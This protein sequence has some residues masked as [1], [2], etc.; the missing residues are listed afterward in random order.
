[1]LTKLCQLVCCT[2]ITSA[3]QIMHSDFLLP[4]VSLHPH[5]NV[6]DFFF[7]FTQKKLKH[8]FWQAIKPPT[9]AT[10][11]MKG[12]IVTFLSVHEKKPGRYNIEIFFSISVLIIAS[13][14]HSAEGF[15]RKISKKV[16]KKFYTRG[17]CFPSS[18]TLVN[19]P[20]MFDIMTLFFLWTSVWHIFW[21]WIHTPTTKNVCTEN[22]F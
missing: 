7:R 9:K 10:S 2:R 8:T 4:C 22:S 3:V 19:F 6:I 5:E 15:Q 17:L 13:E 12:K 11:V 1:M 16:I 20:Q 18:R 21:P 14:C